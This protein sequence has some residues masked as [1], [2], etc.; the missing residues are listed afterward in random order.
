MNWRDYLDWERLPTIFCPGCGLGIG[1]RAILESFAELNWKRE[2]IIMV[3]GIGC[4]SRIP[5]YVNTDSLH[6]LHGRALAFATGVKLSNKDKHVVVITGDGDGVGIGGN[7]MIHAARRNMDIKVFL[8]NNMIYGMTG[9][10]ASPTTPLGAYATTSPYGKYEP[11]FDSV[12]LLKGANATFIARGAVY[13]YLH[14]LNITKRAL[15][16]KGFSFVEILS[17]CPTYFGRLQGIPDPSLF[18]LKQ[19]ETTYRVEMKD[20]IPEEERKKKIPL[21]I[22]VDEERETFEELYENVIR[23]VKNEKGISI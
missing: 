16:H 11:T 9:G 13:F 14:L 3:S 2:D 18:L 23:R 10:Q 1:L 12:E 8:F 15:K 7:H 21:G 5:G 19:K 6:S 20:K 4:S 22:F 17:P